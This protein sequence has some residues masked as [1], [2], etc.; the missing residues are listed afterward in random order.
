MSNTVIPNSFQHP[1]FYIDRLA[2]FLTPTENVVL[3]KAIREILGWHNKIE[4]RKARIALSVF[5]DGKLSKETGEPLCYGCGISKGTVRKALQALD[6]FNILVKDGEPQNDGQMLR[7]IDD[8][9]SIRWDELIKRRDRWAVARGEQT[10]AATLAS[11]EARGVTLDVRGT[12]ERYT[13]VTS[14][15]TPG[16]T[17]NVTKETQ[18]ETQETHTSANAENE[19]NPHLPCAGNDTP[20]EPASTPSSEQASPEPPGVTEAPDNVAFIEEMERAGVAAEYGD[21]PERT[22]EE[23]RAATARASARGK[24]RQREEPWHQWG[25]EHRDLKPRNGVSVAD[26]QRVGHLLESEYG[27]MPL[28]RDRTGVKHWVTKCA[29]L[30]LTADGDMELVRQTGDRLRRDGMVLSGPWSLLNT[31][32]GLAAE[33][34]SAKAT[35]QTLWREGHWDTK[36]K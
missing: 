34:A 31:V 26:I 36:I 11:L 5:V 29:E 10:H 17:S 12:V 3:T 19:S 25:A 13:G 4:A 18:L 32:R 2:Y 7:L 30:W 33:R 14:N 8:E 24:A 15:V 23:L 27:L 22:M 20:S 21:R 16:V 6:D 35:P 1:N 28:W 9:H